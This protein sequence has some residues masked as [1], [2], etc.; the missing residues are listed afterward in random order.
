MDELCP[1]LSGQ[2][3]DVILAVC[4]S[5]RALVV[6]LIEQERKEEGGEAHD[7]HYEGP[8]AQSDCL[9]P[10]TSPHSLK[11]AIKHTLIHD[12]IESIKYHLIDLLTQ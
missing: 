1:L 8:N 10:S 4:Y 2:R 11:K 3:A 9:I 6:I 12:C 7:H 5:I